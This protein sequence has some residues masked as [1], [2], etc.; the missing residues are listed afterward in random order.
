MSRVPM[1]LDRHQVVTVVGSGRRAVITET[2]DEPG[3][4]VPH[5]YSIRLDPPADGGPGVEEQVD[6]DE[7]S[8]ALLDLDDVDAA[9]YEASGQIDNPDTHYNW[10]ALQAIRTA[11]ALR[12][13]VGYLRRILELAPTYT[14]LGPVDGAIQAGVTSMVEYRRA[15]SGGGEP[16]EDDVAQMRDEVEIVVRSVLP[17]LAPFAS[18]LQ[19]LRDI[20]PGPCPVPDFYHGYDMC[21]HGPWQHCTQTIAAWLA[22]GLDPDTERARVVAEAR[23]TYAPADDYDSGDGEW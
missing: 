11:E 23:L 2:H 7:I 9:L 19:K 17:V 1:P 20:L 15:D 13:E 5:A 4:P 18:A 3:S 14:G 21:A 10:A 8:P 6:A 22:R 16:S 12:A